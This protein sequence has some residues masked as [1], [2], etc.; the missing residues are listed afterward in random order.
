MKRYSSGKPGDTIAAIAP[1]SGE[2]G[3]GIV[4]LSGQNSL[5]VA[6]KFFCP[7]PRRK[8]ESFVSH[9]LYY[10]RIFSGDETVDEGM[11]V[12]MRA[13]KTYTREDVVEIHS[14]GGEAVTRKVL[15]LAVKG[16]SRLAE[17]GEFTR[18]AFLNGRIDLA[19]AEGVADIIRAQT[20]EERRL[21][22]V[23]LRGG[24]SG[25]IKELRGRLLNVLAP[26]EASFD[27]PQEGG[28]GGRLKWA[29]ELKDVRAEIDL[30]VNGGEEGIMLKGGVKT[31]IVGAPNAGK[32]SLMNA[33]LRADR[34]LVSPTPGTT[35]DAVEEK[36]RIRGKPFVLVDTAGLREKARELEAMGKRKSLSLMGDADLVVFV[37]D[38][39]QK[40][41]S[42]DEKNARTVKSKRKKTLV[43]I[44]K[45]DLPVKIDMK[46]VRGMFP[47]YPILLLSAKTG[48][49]VGKLTDKMGALCG[50]GSEG[51]QK[52]ILVSRLRHQESLK[53]AFRQLSSALKAS[54]GSEELAACDIRGA[55][56]SLGEITGEAFNDQV[57]D[58]IFQDFC[59]GK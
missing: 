31:V 4:R 20:E 37:L 57:L 12:L 24:L 9:T 5:D 34:V 45:T 23:I 6:L 14:H 7:L 59:V 40:L 47:S 58:K 22:V 54:P 8:K 21:A 19:Q 16:G 43:V 30:L 38:G 17:P 15:T 11:M 3:I 49:G 56:E 48:K 25:K 44:N 2:G 55:F 36:I 35:R 1:P 33:L 32:S 41:V 26:L 53:G 52:A 10:G 29:G 39:N 27:F 28:N 46:K 42:R 13:P 51:G 18:R 50:G